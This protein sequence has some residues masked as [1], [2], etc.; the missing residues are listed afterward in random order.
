VEPE[1]LKQIVE[2]ALLAADEP[3]TVD[4]LAKLFKPSEID[5]NTIRADLREALKLLTEEAEGRGYELVQVAS[6]YRY[7]VRQ[8]LSLWIS[9]LW[10]EKP[11]RYTRAL[12]ETLSLVAYKQPVTRGD[13]EQVRG[14]S[15]SQN[16]MR[17]LLE[18][19]WIR[20]VGQ[21][22]VP[23]RPS[24]YGTTK[25]FLDYFN[26]KSLDQLPPLAEIREL[27]E[28]VMVEI[29]AEEDAAAAAAEASADSVAAEVSDE[30]QNPAEEIAEAD[31]SGLSDDNVTTLHA[32]EDDDEDVDLDGADFDE[33]IAAAIAAADAASERFNNPEPSASGEEPSAS[34]EEPSASG[35]EPSASGEEPSASGE[36]PSASGEEP[37]ASEQEPSV[38]VEPAEATAVDSEAPSNTPEDPE[39][40]ERAQVVDVVTDLEGENQAGADSPEHGDGEQPSGDDQP[41]AEVVQLPRAPH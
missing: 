16:I 14:V 34:G 21:R 17:T 20:V 6:G 2:A 23:G 18:R 15:V 11:P 35:E 30:D 1:K 26:L 41:T 5:K 4:Q 29:E 25:E 28:P 32:F 8:E 39:L 31:A 37:S 38:E 7:Q 9:R 12:L 27:I 3:L 33:E 10:E 40:S 22:E 13:I 19:G 24:M 36:E